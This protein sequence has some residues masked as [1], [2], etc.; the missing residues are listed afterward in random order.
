MPKIPTTDYVTLAPDWACEMLSVETRELDLEAKRPVYARE[1]VAHLWLIDPRDR[2][3]QAFELRK[4]GWMLI[5]CAKDDEPVCVRPFDVLT[6]NLGDL[7][8]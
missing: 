7:R 6:F 5:G 2:T 8:P 4:G 3:L 1:G